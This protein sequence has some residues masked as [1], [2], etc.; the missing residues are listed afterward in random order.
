MSRLQ[1]LKNKIRSN[2]DCV[3][4][5]RSICL[6]CSPRVPR[7]VARCCCAQGD[8]CFN[9]LLLCTASW[10]DVLYVRVAGGRRAWTRE[11]IGHGQREKNLAAKN[12]SGHWLLVIIGR[13]S[14]AHAA[15]L[16]QQYDMSFV[17]GPWCECA[18]THARHDT[19]LLD[20][21]V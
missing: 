12:G 2:A 21:V 18:Y 19:C 14:A 5:V 8:E 9:S 11:R 13:G 17:S 20:S 1:P 7:M 15:S 10:K 3:A 6:G 4:L 16:S